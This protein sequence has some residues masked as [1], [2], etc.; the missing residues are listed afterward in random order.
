[1]KKEE[2]VLGEKTFQRKKIHFYFIK[3]F[4]TKKLHF[5]IPTQYFNSPAENIT[6]F[7]RKS[8][9]GF[10]NYY[11]LL[12]QPSLNERVAL[13]LSSLVGANLHQ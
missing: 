10:K 12:G 2:Y 3:H 4:Q 7:L 9:R 1:M 8:Y 13:T 6:N 11:K 5:Y